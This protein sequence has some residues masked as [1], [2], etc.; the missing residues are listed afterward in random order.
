MPVTVDW[1]NAVINV[2]QS[3]LTSLGGGKYELDVNQFRL[4]LRDLEDDVQ[5]MAWPPTHDHTTTKTLGGVTFARS[6]EI[7]SP[8]TVTFEDGQYT[9]VATGANH[10]IAD[11]KNN[12]QV[13]LITQNSAGLIVYDTGGGAFPTVGQIAA[14]VWQY[15]IENG[16][17]AEWMMRCLVAEALGNGT[18]PDGDGTYQFMSLDGLK[19]RIEGTIA[20]GARTVTTKDG[21]P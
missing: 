8:Y 6:V 11:V 18:V 3:Y 9:V 21:D 7:L 1:P 17:A 15:V 5:G 2:P 13:S 14:A 20:A 4:D 10:N 12:N 16:K 19:A